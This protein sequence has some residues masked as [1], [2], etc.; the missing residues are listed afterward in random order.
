MRRSIPSLTTAALLLAVPAA[1]AATFGSPVTARGASLPY[2]RPAVS[3]TDS[4]RTALAFVDPAPGGNG[5]QISA[6]RGTLR[7][8]VGQREL[9]TKDGTSPVV[10]QSSSS[11]AVAWITYASGGVRRVR[12]RVSRDR[13]RFRELQTLVSVKANVT[14]QQVVGLTGG[15]FLVIWWQ[16]VPGTGRHAVRYAVSSASGRFGMIRELAA[17]T[18]PLSSV[19][20]ASQPDGSAVAAWGTP[21]APPVN[22]QVAVAAL[23]A[24]ATTFGP[25]RQ[26]DAVNVAAGAMSAGITATAG[27]G[28]TAV[29][30]SES[31]S[32]PQ[33]LR[34]SI[35][36]GAPETVLAVDSQDLGALSASGPV[37]ALPAEGAALAAWTVVTAIPGDVST[38]T[39]G[40]VL[41]ATRA[42]D[43]TYPG[44][45]RLSA[46]GAVATSPTTAGS[47]NL[48]IVTWGEGTRQPRL[49][50]ATRTAGG[51]F[52]STR[53]LASS[54]K[55]PAVVGAARAGALAAWMTPGN[56]LLLASLI[57]D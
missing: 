9:I 41:A 32:L 52:S 17:D 37:L 36:G 18:G 11:T 44:A 3:V 25:P 12:V 31:G 19:S 55:G 16:G 34:T 7:R 53:T 46:A 51:T 40:E 45:Q 21:L 33:L 57:D 54:A 5:L 39:G 48:G 15:R 50:Y 24:G 47:E 13:G 30:W 14:S 29:T 28:G 20:A 22:Q 56:R 2:A 8:P 38:I 4:G 23:K 10:A 42:S 1:D 43:G 49:R 26:I 27:P 35:E 6:R